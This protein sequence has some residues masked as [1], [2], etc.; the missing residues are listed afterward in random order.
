MPESNLNLYTEVLV[1]ERLLDDKERQ[2]EH[3]RKTIVGL[4]SFGRAYLN[5][6][7]LEIDVQRIRVN[8]AKKY[9]EDTTPELKNS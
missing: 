4:F 7:Q 9:L 3:G 1:A 2:I 5:R 6:K 8:A